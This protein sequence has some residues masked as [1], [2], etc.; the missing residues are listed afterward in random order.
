MLGWLVVTWADAQQTKPAPATPI[1]VKKSELGK[2]VW[3]PTW[4]AIVEKAV[5][6]AMLSPM[7]TH[8]VARFCPRFSSMSE[9]DKRAFWAYF[10]QALAGAE[11]G[12]NPTARIR[13]TEPEVAK[14][15]K[16]T[17]AAIRSEGLL[18]L[19]YQDGELYGCDFDWKADRKLPPNSPARTILQPKNNLECG[20]KILSNQ[21]IDKH[22]PLLTRTSYW[23]PLQPGAGS[24]TQ[25]TTFTATASMGSTPSQPAT[26]VLNIVPVTLSASPTTVPAG[27]PVTLTYGGP[28]NGSSWVLITVGNNNPTPLPAPSCSGNSCMGTYTTGPINTN[29]TFQMAATGPAGGQAVSPQVTI[30]VG[31]TPAIASFAV[32]PAIAGPGQF[33]N[34][35]WSTMNATT[36]NVTPVINQDDQILPLNSTAYSYNTNGLMQA[37]NFVAVASAGSAQSPPASLVLMMVPVTLS[38]TPTTIGAGQS[39]TL[40]YGGP[41]NGSAWSL[42]RLAITSQ[43]RFQRPLAAVISAM[44]RILRVLSAATRRLRLR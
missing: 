33:V 28:N 44:A 25:T 34:S 5:P 14:I 24:L 30:T 29:T 3:D 15:D 21:L 38:A 4:D 18:Q 12:L 40:T 27:S 16:V 10:F 43:L 32:S 31:S 6:P 13:H 22:R 26:V 42:T 7:G 39:V 37:T 23:S 1:D 2:K 35:S 8:D 20:V 19:S 9:T 11:A 36:F 17:G 41:N